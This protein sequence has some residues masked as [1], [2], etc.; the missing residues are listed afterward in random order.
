VNQSSFI[1]FCKTYAGD[2]W[3]FD[4][5]WRS[6]L[7][8]NRD[9]LPF[10]ASAP[11]S[12][13]ELFK[14]RIGSPSD[15]T[16]LSDEEIVAANPRSTI[17]RYLAWDGRRSQQVVKAEAWRLVDCES[18]L[19]IDSESEFLRDFRISDFVHPSGSP[20]TVV[21]QD[22][23]LLQLAANKR[24]DKVLI[25][26]AADAARGRAIF[27]RQG[28]D[29]AFGPTPVIWSK[30]VWRDLDERCLMD[31]G[32]TLWD[33]IDS[34]PSELHWYGEAL[35]HFRSIPLLPIGPLF[36]VYHY[37]WQWH[38]MRRLRENSAT[39]KANYLGLLRQSNWDYSRDSGLGNRRRN[40][41]SRTLRAA[42]HFLSRFR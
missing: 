35:L 3:R 32:W 34:F 16:W 33:A 38:A 18:Y 13:L 14:E 39:I 8:Y 41:F 20:Y 25:D 23:E 26:N 15:L 1:L 11:A 10:Y 2:L 30:A 37:N 17:D 40:A 31:R 24:I 6:V 29:Y 4:R 28:P 21:H 42:K 22:K 27:N 5:L 7:K 9:K 12:E 36:R 19:C